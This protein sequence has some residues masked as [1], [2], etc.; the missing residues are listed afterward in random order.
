MKLTEQEWAFLKK[1]IEDVKYGR[2][3]IFCSPNKKTLDFTVE[4]TYKLPVKKNDNG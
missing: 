3:I 1:E 2:I 4:Q